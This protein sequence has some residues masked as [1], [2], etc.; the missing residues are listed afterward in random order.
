MQTLTLASTDKPKNIICPTC[1]GFFF[2]CGTTKTVWQKKND[3]TIY[4]PNWPRSPLLNETVIVQSRFVHQNITNVRLTFQYSLLI[5]RC[6]TGCILL[7]LTFPWSWMLFTLLYNR[8]LSEPQ[9]LC[10][11]LWEINL[12]WM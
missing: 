1:F 7:P 5:L 12:T 3:E 4:C 9:M 10:C 6:C 11:R 8:L 2:V